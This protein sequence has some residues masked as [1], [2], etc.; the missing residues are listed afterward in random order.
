MKSDRCELFRV[1]G[2]PT[3]VK[4]IELLKSRGPL[5]VK[6]IAEVICITPAAVSQH[7]KVLRQAGLVR[8]ERQGYWIPYSVDEEGLEDCCDVLTD[9]CTCGHHGFRARQPDRP[10]L[11]ALMRY[12]EQLEKELRDTE[13]RIAE[14]KKQGK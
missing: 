11:E 3:R 14:L 9:V 6:N 5:G 7:L 8:S 1:L 2:V 12:K 4:I 10:S 13:K